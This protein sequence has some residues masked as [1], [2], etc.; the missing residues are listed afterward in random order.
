MSPS[1]F[2][3]YPL[4]HLAQQAKQ[5]S[6]RKQKHENKRRTNGK[7]LAAREHRDKDE[8]ATDA[9]HDDACNKCENELARGSTVRVAHSDQNHRCQ[10]VQQPPAPE[11]SDEAEPNA[12]AM[13]K[14][15]LDKYLKEAEE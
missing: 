15:N 14:V 6:L 2:G 1:S 13:R 7:T 5:K 4:P 11:P 10:N 8:Q 12:Y 3:E 9:K